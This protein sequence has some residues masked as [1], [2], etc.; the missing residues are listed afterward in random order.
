M[1]S[2][3]VQRALGRFN[4]LPAA[5]SKYIANTSS[6][7]GG[8]FFE[9]MP[10]STR[11]SFQ[12]AECQEIVSEAADFGDNIRLS[13]A[14]Y[15]FLYDFVPKSHPESRVLYLADFQKFKVIDQA[16]GQPVRGSTIAVVDGRARVGEK[17]CVIHPALIRQGRG[18][19]KDVLLVK[20][21]I[22][23]KLDRPVV[24]KGK[25]RKPDDTCIKGTGSA[26]P[27][28]KDVPQASEK[29][30]VDK[31]GCGRTGNCDAEATKAAFV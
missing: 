19:D 18:G 23:V 10:G 31:D 4:D 3:D 9:L 2:T 22:L 28:A 21:T 15:Q 27:T 14:A 12:L 11:N 16:S 25:G 13:A 17:L 6:V 30:C 1:W 20:A 26:D 5:R 29:D 7:I 8:I 24:R